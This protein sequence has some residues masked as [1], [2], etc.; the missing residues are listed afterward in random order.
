MDKVVT[1]S[2]EIELAWGTHDLGVYP[3]LSDGR[4]EEEFYLR[5]LLAHCDEYGIP[6]T[7]DIVGH[8]L[9]E[10]C[11]GHDGPHEPGWFDNDPETDADR[12]PLFYWPEVVNLIHDMSVDHEICTHTFSHVLCDEVESA[13]IDWEF[14]QVMELH[15]AKSIGFSESF[16]PPRHQTP[17]MDKLKQHDIRIVRT[18]KLPLYTN[19]LDKYRLR[20]RR[21]LTD[22][23]Y[24]DFKPEYI[25]GVLQT[26]TT[27]YP[28]LSAVHLPIGQQDPLLPFRAVPRPIRKRRHYQ[29]LEQT[30]KTP[31][32]YVHHWSHLL[33]IA[34]EAQWEPIKAFLTTL[35]EKQHSDEVVIRTM[36]E[37]EPIISPGAEFRVIPN[38]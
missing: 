36:S 13:V 29:F 9:L 4:K 32:P 21:W 16:V 33:N 6:I 17:P 25:E 15:E 20:L 5:Q 35:S 24:P 8:L 3:H 22:D 14:N 10:E 19:I 2:I 28:S 27:Q 18:H 11:D 26:Y 38:P 34:N 31:A 23:A 30:L 12:D 37:L 1:L 7:F